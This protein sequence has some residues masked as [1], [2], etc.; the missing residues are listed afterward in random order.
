MNKETETKKEPKKEPKKRTVSVLREYFELIMEVLVFVF[1]IN[2]FL[3]QTYVIPSS[4]MEDTMLVG[5]HL[6]VDKVSYSPSFNGLERLLLPQLELKRGMLVT[7]TGPSEINKGMEA[8]NLV[9]RL[10]AVSGDTIRVERD[11]V[12]INGE[13]SNEPYVQFKGGIPYDV[14]PPDNPYQWH[15][16]F[17]IEFRESLADTPQ[18]KAF[19]I[20]PGYYFCMGDNRNNS[21][22]S[23]SW[24]PV[25]A[26][27]IIGR[28]WRVYWSYE[29][30]SHEYLNSNLMY[31]I[32]DFFVTLANFVTKTRWER[33]FKKYQE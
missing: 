20:P 14:F 15:Y 24:G 27:F 33:T 1:F 6:L 18:G 5:D 31:K 7:F 8:K 28:P 10:I 17:P 21:F 29:A 30:S 12:Y 26:H 25:P 11:K 13:L 23:R 19:R 2:A 3:L 9:K 16:E 32:K 22:D 4:S